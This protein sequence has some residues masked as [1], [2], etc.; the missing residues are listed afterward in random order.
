MLLVQL[1]GGLGTVQLTLHGG[2]QAGSAGQLHRALLFV[3]PVVVGRVGAR[4]KGLVQDHPVQH[5]AHRDRLGGLLPCGAQ[6]AAQDVGVVK[7]KAVKPHGVFQ[8]G[9]FLQESFIIHCKTT[10]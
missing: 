10:P 4:Q 1:P 5:N 3:H 2:A 8:L 7:I 6:R 9:Q